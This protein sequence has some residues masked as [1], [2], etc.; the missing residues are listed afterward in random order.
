MNKVL[1]YL[2]TLLMLIL[3]IRLIYKLYNHLC[4]NMYL[5]VCSMCS[6]SVPR[7]GLGLAV[8]TFSS[9]LLALPIYHTMGSK[10]F[11]RCIIYISIIKSLQFQNR[12]FYKLPTYDELANRK[13]PLQ[14]N[15]F[16]EI[17]MRL[18]KDFGTIV[19]QHA[20]RQTIT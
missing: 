11:G 19:Y 2:R 5:S 9:A 4:S 13:L 7:V 12:I 20:R 10:P 3:L 1:G 18:K 8:L 16:K 6:A 15:L 14:P 17:H